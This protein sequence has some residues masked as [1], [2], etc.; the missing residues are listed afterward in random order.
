M[1]NRN[2]HCRRK[3]SRLDRI[4]RKCDFIIAELSALGKVSHV[5][6]PIDEL[7]DR[8]HESA[9]RMRAEALED[10]RFLRKVFNSKRRSYD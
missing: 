5:N 6:H 4:E 10:R 8:M 9:R 1:T 7:I 2:N 3:P